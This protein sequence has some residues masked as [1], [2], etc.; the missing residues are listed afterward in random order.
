MKSIKILFILAIIAFSSLTLAQSADSIAV[1]A[2]TAGRLDLYD[3]SNGQ[4]IGGVKLGALPHEIELS[5]D[6]KTAYITN[7]GLQD[8]D[9]RIG[10]PGNNISVIDI[11]TLK[12]QYRLFTGADNAP[13]GIK[14]RPQHENEL[15][16][17][18]EKDNKIIIFDLHT[19]QIIKKFNA[20][21]NTHNFI[22]SPDGK[23]LWLMSGQ[24]GVIKMN[25]ET[26]KI[27]ATFTLHTPIHG[28]VYT[29][30]YKYIMASG[31][32]EIAFFDPLTLKITNHFENLGVD[33]ILYSAITP[34][35][36][37]IVA[38]AAW[39]NEVL[40][41]DV[42]QKKVIRRLVTGIDP[43]HVIIDT[44]GKYA[45]VSNARSSHITKINLT[46]FNT[47]NISTTAGPNGIA[48]TL[49]VKKPDILTVGALLPLTGSQAKEGR[50]LML[51]YEFWKNIINHTGGLV[52]SNRLHLIK[53]V[54]RDT[55]SMTQTIP[56]ETEDLIKNEHAEI[57]F[58]LPPSLAQAKEKKTASQL[59][60]ALI[61]WVTI[62]NNF[63][64]PTQLKQK[65]QHQYNLTMTANAQQAF[66][67]GQALE[68]ILSK[69]L[70]IPAENGRFPGIILLHTSA[71]V[72]QW[73]RNWAEL[74]KKSGYAVYIS[75]SFSYRD[76]QDRKTVGWD[77]AMQAQLTDIPNAF[78]IL[79]GSSHV[80]N[81]RIGLL[82]FSLGGFSTLKAMELNTD[83]PD[84]LK[85]LPIKAAISFYGHCQRLNNPQFKNVIEILVGEQDDRS[86][87][88]ACQQLLQNNASTNQH[89]T[90]KIYAN[91]KHG[92][93]NPFLPNSTLLISET[94]EKYHLG[95]E[96]TA[97]EKSI[98]DVLNFLGKNL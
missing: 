2:Q 83:I 42:Q 6:Q 88:K 36:K 73:D 49:P 21:P 85:Q 98:K 28:I 91:A 39:N 68:D 3:S 32:N 76:Y 96:K 1:V 56:S 79:T 44:T 26:G 82:G 72:K 90:L 45:Y 18:T 57:L 89:V 48:L 70:Y 31:N 77:K 20:V 10:K 74:L 33:Q 75:D 16:V 37:Y 15:Y 93:D 8:Y 46:N 59:G 86:P 4:H 69:N 58:S 40:I 41:I 62:N 13:H 81:K 95:Y 7:F 84:D 11:T 65:F 52:I 51:G 34:D 14:L 67:N 5:P 50:E 80:D 54:Y 94:G 64:L 9:E 38:P 61:P 92:F 60:R 17:N 19:K 47:E 97:R 24:N 78:L 53:I 30:H 71:G 29:P 27:F 22:F 12:E 35:G 25:A 66:R 87:A 43:V 23:I 63:S 55:Q